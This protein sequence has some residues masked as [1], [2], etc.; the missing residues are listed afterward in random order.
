MPGDQPDDEERL[1]PKVLIGDRDPNGV[2]QLGD[3]EH[4][5]P[6]L[7]GQQGDQVS[8]VGD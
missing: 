8:P 2:Q 1:A 6:Q 4:Q 5:R 7:V 3:D